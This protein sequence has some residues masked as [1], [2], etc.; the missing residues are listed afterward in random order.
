MKKHIYKLLSALFIIVLLSNCAKD[1]TLN[2]H[3]SNTNK[4]LS[5]IEKLVNIY[6]D[7]FID[8]N[9]SLAPKRWEN[10]IRYASNFIKKADLPFQ[11]EQEQLID[12]YFQQ[13]AKLTGLTIIKESERP[14]TTAV[15][16][17][18]QNWRE[19]ALNWKQFRDGDPQTKGLTN[20]QYKNYLDNIS[21]TFFGRSRE[22]NGYRARYFSLS[23]YLTYDNAL[24]DLQSFVLFSVSIANTPDYPRLNQTIFGLTP[25]RSQCQNKILFPIDKAY[26]HS[27]YSP[28]LRPYY[29]KERTMDK[30]D[31]QKL[32]KM[33]AYLMVSYLEEHKLTQ[34]VIAANQH[35]LE[36]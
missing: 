14:K 35:L 10:E 32:R 13:V 34:Q 15:L 20:A 28:E 24:C 12:F 8:E 5:S 17:F 4:D 36:K 3:T 21:G 11:K 33:L 1:N 30:K 19:I 7:A 22:E 27:A 18:Y 6:L 26:L 23:D 16:F 9:V 29:G 2:E 31:I 25:V